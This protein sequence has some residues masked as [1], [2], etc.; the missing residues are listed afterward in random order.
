[1]HSLSLLPVTLFLAIVQVVSATT[2]TSAPT[3]RARLTYVTTS[4]YSLAT[5]EIPHDEMSIGMGQNGTKGNYYW[6]ACINE[7]F[8]TRGEYGGCGSD[9][10]YTRCSGKT[11]FGIDGK[12]ILCHYFESQYRDQCC[13]NGRPK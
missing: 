13:P 6:L 8:T 12:G 10:L 2:A 5:T 1:M 3:T 9:D 4:F 11:A 7:P